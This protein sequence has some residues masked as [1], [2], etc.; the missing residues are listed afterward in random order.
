MVSGSGPAGPFPTLTS[1][2]G[3]RILP[4]RTRGNFDY[5]PH[6]DE[7]GGRFPTLCGG[8][9]RRPP[10]GT[11]ATRPRG[12]RRQQPRRTALGVTVLDPVHPSFNWAAFNF[13]AIWLRPQWY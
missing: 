3:G 1:Q 2:Q 5:Y 4:R 10:A 7:G 8:P 13:A 11:A 12:V 6:V 9:R